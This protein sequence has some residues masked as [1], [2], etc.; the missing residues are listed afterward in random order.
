M[1]FAYSVEALV[2]ER[3]IMFLGSG[4]LHASIQGTIL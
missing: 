3:R 4:R 2:N 1:S